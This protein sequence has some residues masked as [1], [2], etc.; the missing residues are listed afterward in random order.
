MQEIWKDITGYEGLY[1]V[2][3]AGRIKSFRKSSRFRKP[4]EYILTPSVS[5]NGYCQVTLYD[6]AERH[7][8][9]VHRLVAIS[10]IDNP[11]NYSFIN[12]KD[13]NKL[14]NSADNL[15]WCTIA[16]NNSYG[17]GRFRSIITKSKAVE[18]YLPDGQFLAKYV[19]ISV[20]SEITGIPKSNIKSCLFIYTFFK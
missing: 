15:E 14:N 9:L 11:N 19:C 8:F 12:H 3:N 1:Q 16:Y 10:F 4:D 6:G 2:S 5:N 20:A 17:T 18:Q 7:K 13:E